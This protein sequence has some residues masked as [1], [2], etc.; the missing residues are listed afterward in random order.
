[1]GNRIRDW[2][3]IDQHY[4]KLLRHSF[5]EL[6]SPHHTRAAVEAISEIVAPIT[7]IESAVELGCG[8]AP[9]LDELK[10][11]SKKTLGVT[12]LQEPINHEVLRRDMH[13][14]GLEDASYDLVIMRHALEHSPMPLMMLMEVHR[15]SKKY[16]LII[17]P[18]PNRRM[19]FTW[20][21]HY[22]VFEK[23]TWEKLFEAANFK[24]Y[25]FKKVAYLEIAPGEW[26]QEYR[27]LLVKRS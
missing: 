23:E 11:M 25:T 26:D 1:M 16:A 27:F 13:F 6:A 15:I 17:V 24:I 9:C 10:K 21:D 20:A 12:M 7:E 18:V 22:S 19:I 4:Q 3:I 14:S 5:L 2:R 8:T